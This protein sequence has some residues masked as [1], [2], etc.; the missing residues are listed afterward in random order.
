MSRSPWRAPLI[1]LAALLILVVGGTILALT[2]TGCGPQI[3]RGT[4]AGDGTVNKATDSTGFTE[5]TIKLS[6]GRELVCL[7]W[8][9]WD[10]FHEGMSS[11]VSCDWG[12]TEGGEE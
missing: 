11:G 7:T 2:L 6:D 9:T 5:N 8:S 1:A 3:N 10:P 4:S 12:I